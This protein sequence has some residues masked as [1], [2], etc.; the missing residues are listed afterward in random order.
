MSDV[1]VDRTALEAAFL[2]LTS[3]LGDY[4]MHAEDAWR[5][6]TG[7]GNPAGRTNLRVAL[8]GAIGDVAVHVR[9]E[10]DAGFAVRDRLEAILEQF[11]ALD[12]SMGIDGSP[13]SG[14]DRD[15][16]DALP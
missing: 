6:E 11:T 14:W 4:G 10:R 1:E 5:R 15:F 16:A 9:N 12:V 2:A 13:G 7:V 8:E 3:S